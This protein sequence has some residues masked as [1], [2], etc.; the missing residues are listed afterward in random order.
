MRIAIVHLDLGLGGAERQTIDEALAL[1]AGGHEV[2][3]ITTHHTKTR[4]FAETVDP[5]TYFAFSIGS[6]IRYSMV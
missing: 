1:K 2:T 5:G 3:I 6:F 4:C